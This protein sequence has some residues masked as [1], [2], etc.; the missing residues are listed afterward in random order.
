[1]PGDAGAGG[2]RSPS[3]SFPLFL[4][5]E[6]LRWAGLQD[7]YR[8]VIAFLAAEMLALRVRP[9]YSQTTP[10]KGSVWQSFRA[11]ADL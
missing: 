2:G 7:P 9:D 4:T 1:M 5:K 8:A 11:R 3:A 10:A 6:Q